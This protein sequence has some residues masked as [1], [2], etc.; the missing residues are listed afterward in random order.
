MTWCINGNSVSVSVSNKRTFYFLELVIWKISLYSPII[1]YLPEAIRP[2][3]LKSLL[4]SMESN[5]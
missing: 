3:D 1:V 2:E 4:S 5:D